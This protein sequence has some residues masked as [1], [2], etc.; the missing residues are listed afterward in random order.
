MNW[1]I[2][3][4]PRDFE[5]DPDGRR[6]THDLALLRLPLNTHATSGRVYL[7]SGQLTASDVQRITRQLLLD[8]AIELAEVRDEATARQPD[9]A[10]AGPLLKLP[11]WRNSRMSISRTPPRGFGVK[12]V[13]GLG[14]KPSIGLP[15]KVTW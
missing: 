8:A 7:L 9:Q 4:R 15:W 3:L 12:L 11:F 6:L 13:T 1:E 14:G 5:V 10:D 2:T